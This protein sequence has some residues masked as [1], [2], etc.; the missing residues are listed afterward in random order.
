MD[1][2]IGRIAVDKKSGQAFKV[3]E[4]DRDVLFSKPDAG[5]SVFASHFEDCFIIDPEMFAEKAPDQ[6]IP[7]DQGPVC[8][9]V[10]IGHTDEDYQIGNFLNAVDQIV[11]SFMRFRD[12]STSDLWKALQLYGYTEL[13]GEN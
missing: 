4:R 5:G 9:M 6:D 10:R 12:C 8:L 7:P 11:N 13:L 1:N 2:V 3:V